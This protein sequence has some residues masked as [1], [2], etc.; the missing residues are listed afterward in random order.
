MKFVLHLHENTNRLI[1]HKTFSRH[2][3]NKDGARFAGNAVVNAVVVMA[4]SP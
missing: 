2:I 3:K 4:I 1:P